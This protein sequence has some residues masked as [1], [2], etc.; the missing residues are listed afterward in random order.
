MKTGFVIVDKHGRSYVHRVTEYKSIFD[1]ALPETIL[2]LRSNVDEGSSGRHLEPEF[3]SVAFHFFFFPQSVFIRFAQNPVD[4]QDPFIVRH[5]Q[6]DPGCEARYL[7]RVVIGRDKL[8]MIIQHRIA[9]VLVSV[10][11]AERLG[12]PCR[13]RVRN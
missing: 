4:A 8:Q 11:T 3:F 10:D 13:I 6:G 12:R 1:T 5:Y 9:Q 2:N 7:V